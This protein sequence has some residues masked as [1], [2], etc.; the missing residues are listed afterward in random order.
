MRA[1]HAALLVALAFVTASAAPDA[2]AGACTRGGLWTRWS[3]SLT[4]RR[5]DCVDPP[6]DPPSPLPMQLAACWVSWMTRPRTFRVRM[7]GWSGGPAGRGEQTARRPHSHSTPTPCCSRRAFEGREGRPGTRW[8]YGCEA[9]HQRVSAAVAH[10]ACRL[11]APCRARPCDSSQL[12]SCVRLQASRGQWVPRVQ[13]ACL[14]L[15]E[16]PAR[17]DRRVSRVSRRL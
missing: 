17:T 10:G 6:F 14:V 12:P 7:V 16:C 4:D 11:A 2:P 8:N 9:R 3:N 15:R 13:P 5:F 1:H